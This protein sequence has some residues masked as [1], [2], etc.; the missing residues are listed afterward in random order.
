VRDAGNRSS[1]ASGFDEARK[2]VAIVSAPSASPGSDDRGA[3]RTGSDTPLNIGQE[4]TLAALEEAFPI[5]F[6]QGDL[7]KLG[8]A[9]GL[10]L[11]ESSV[12]AH[13]PAGLPQLSLPIAT[14]PVGSGCE[15]AASGTSAAAGDIAAVVMADDPA[16]L[17]PLRGRSI[18]E[19]AAPCS[20]TQKRL[21]GRELASVGNE[22]VWWQIDAAAGPTGV[23][24]Y[25]L[26]ALGEG[27]ALR[28]HMRAGRFMGLLPLVQF[29]RQL[30]GS[31]GWRAPAPR[32]SFIIDDP[33]LHRPSYGFLDYRGLAEHA[34]CHGYHVA[35]ATVPIDGWLAD[36]RACEPFA[37]GS[38]A[39]SLLIHGNDHVA[40]ELAHL[41][42]DRA[43]LQA[44]A[45]ALRRI[46]ALERRSGVSVDRVMAPPHGAC[47][48]EALRAMFRLGFEAVCISR[49]YP[50]LDGM[51]PPTPLAGW[52]PAEMVAGGLP[53]L[54]R[55]PISSARE[56]LAL[57]TLL[58]QPLILY[59]HHGDLADGLDVLAQAAADIN[60]LGEFRW[61]PL[62]WIARGSYATRLCGESMLV[63]MFARRIE[64]EVPAGVR[65]V[66][67]L[68]QEPLGG[69]AGH[70]LDYRGGHADLAFHDGLGVSQTMTVGTEA[71]MDL[72]IVPDRALSPTAVPSPAVK[73]WPWLRR[74]IVEG[75]DRLEAML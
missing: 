51:A 18:P 69:A 20:P 66:R 24:A 13:R 16:L 25:P 46:A 31:E 57:R 10:L 55:Y 15:R 74:A 43:A 63:T 2:L 56:D 26:A 59:G 4:R 54:P 71:H 53:V 37:E 62:S 17:R 11:L 33:N 49:P 50:W 29:L 45:Q 23:S 8:G 39:L 64:L 75:R 32:A 28:D 3:S 70:R 65:E 41:D 68:V 36:R 73:P 27:E 14:L 21:A 58:G 44:M 38:S 42:S 7:A 5:R 48:Q 52:R 40:R 72:T 22:P 12:R 47:S 67:V 34:A 9:D 60:D 6:V 61:G 30:L 35:I 1:A 19:S